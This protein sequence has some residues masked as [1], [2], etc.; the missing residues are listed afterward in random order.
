MPTYTFP[1]SG[2]TI[3]WAGGSGAY[4]PGPDGV[5]LI[6][7]GTAPVT[8]Q[9]TTPDWDDTT[10][11]HGACLGMP[12]NRERHQYGFDRRLSMTGVRTACPFVIPLGEAAVLVESKPAD[13]MSSGTWTPTGY[14]STNSRSIIKFMDAVCVVAWDPTDA[15]STSLTP[16]L[17]GTNDVSKGFRLTNIGNLGIPQSMLDY[18]KLPSVVDLSAIAT[19][20]SVDVTVF[21]TLKTNLETLFANFMGDIYSGW[22]TDT[23]TPGM[24]HPGYGTYL[25]GAVS[26][27]LV[28]L[29]SDRYDTEAK[30]PL[31]R[32]LAQAGLHL[33]GAMFDGR[34]MIANG[35][36]CQGRKALIAFFGWLSGISEFEFMSDFFKSVGGTSPFREDVCYRDTTWWSGASSSDRWLAGWAYNSTGTA[37][38]N[39]D[40]LQNAPSTWGDVDTWGSWASLM[41]AY[42]PP[43]V[44][45]DI[46]TALFFA[47]VGSPRAWSEGGVRMCAQWMASSVTSL[48]VHT[49]MAAI[50]LD[51]S[52]TGPAWGEDYSVSPNVP[53]LQAQA[54]L[55]HYADAIAAYGDGAPGLPV[56]LD[57][58]VEPSMP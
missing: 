36:H 11:Y 20:L 37:N 15:A 19:A 10:G 40:A 38:S 14:S 52:A 29:A 2:R 45:A 44:G 18:S 4:G 49:D 58:S 54:W 46:G 8:I 34:Q 31:A 3:T 7:A 5:L 22:S 33:T 53:G 43:T 55:A 32:S 23:S 30:T 27:A 26:Q 9:S 13:E 24:Q 21:D 1:Y 41:Q 16:P 28:L 6:Q 47:L 12:G 39:G 48:P 35:G 50:G 57:D 56:G 25:A 51:F 42:M 17:L